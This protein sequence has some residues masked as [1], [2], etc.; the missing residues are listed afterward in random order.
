MSNQTILHYQITE[1]IYV[2]ARALL[3]KAI[4]THNGNTVT[5][6]TTNSDFPSAAEKERLTREYELAKNLKHPNIAEV[7]NIMPFKNTFVLEKQFVEG[8]TVR[9]YF[10]KHQPKLL[11]TVEIAIQIVE[12]LSY[13]HGRHIINKDINGNNII[14]NPNTQK[15]SLIDFGISTELSREIAEAKS[16]EQLEGTL[17]YIAPEQTG[18]VNKALDHRCD[19][20]SVGVLLYKIFT[21]RLPFIY[22]DANELVYA[23]IAQTPEPPHFIK[24]TIP[25]VVSEIILK[26]MRK[27]A[28]ER[29]QS[30]SGLLQD[31]KLCRRILKET[32]LL[33]TFPIGRFDVS[34]KFIVS[35]KLYGREAERAL[36]FEKF[37]SVL[38]EQK[39][40]ITLVTG[41]SGVGKSM[42]INEIQKSLVSARGF[43]AVGKFEQLQQNIPYSAFKRAFGELIDYVSTGAANSIAIWRERILEAVAGNGQILIE[44]IPEIESI[45]GQQEPL[46]QLPALEA[47]NRM[48]FTL[49]R[50]IRLF[51]T[52]EHP[53]CVFIDD[54][55]WADMA[56]I[57]FLKN[58]LSSA[59]DKFLYFIG[60]YRDNEVDA[61]HPIMALFSSIKEEGTELSY[62][63]VKNL[64]QE[65]VANLVADTLNSDKTDSLQELAKIVYQKTSGNAFFVNRLL[66]ALNQDKLISFDNDKEKWQWD[67]ESVRQKRFTD[68]VVA[69][70]S[71]K[72][73]DL[74]DTCTYLLSVAAVLGNEFD[75]AFLAS[76]VKKTL[77]EVIKLLRPAL[78]EQLL[79]KRAEHYAFQHDRIQEAAY[80]LTSEED[81]QKLHYDLAILSHQDLVESGQDT[82]LFEVVNHY[83]NAIP[84][85]KSE[86]EQ[87]SLL[88]LNTQAAQKAYAANAFSSA[89]G[90]LAHGKKIFR[91]AYWQTNYDL[92]Y[93]FYELW[94]EVE[95]QCQRFEVSEELALEATDKA[96]TA[97]DKANILNML[98][99]HQMLRNEPKSLDTGR[100]ALALLGV[101]VPDDAN[102]PQAVGESIGALMGTIAGRRPAEFLD[103][104]TCA[105]RNDIVTLRVLTNLAPAAFVLGN[106]LYWTFVIVNAARLSIE[107][108]NIAESATAY[109]SLGI[110]YG[111]AFS[112]YQTGYELGVL[113]LQLTEKY[114]NQRIRTT[115]LFVM[116]N[117]LH[118]W[119]RP[120]S[121]GSAIMAEAVDTGMLS[122]ELLFASYAASSGCLSH[123]YAASTLNETQAA[124]KRYLE[125]CKKANNFYSIYMAT[126][127]SYLPASLT[128]PLMRDTP[129]T[130]EQMSMNQLEENFAKVNPL[131]AFAFYQSVAHSELYLGNYE[132]ALQEYI[133]GEPA[134]PAVVGNVNQIDFFSYIPIISQA[135]L[136]LS[137]NEAICQEAR[138]C[139][140]AYLPK[141]EMLDGLY[142]VN[143]SHKVALVRAM[144]AAAEGD[145]NT[146][147]DCFDTAI[148]MARDNGFLADYALAY[149]LAAVYYAQQKRKKIHEIYLSEAY[150]IYQQWGATEK[151]ARLDNQYAAVL[152]K[153]STSGSSTTSTRA[154]TTTASTTS[155]RDTISS[156][157]DLSSV[158]KAYTVLSSE[159]VLDK[160][161]DKLLSIVNENAGAQRGVLLLKKNSIFYVASDKGQK[162]AS[163]SLKN[164]ELPE[165]LTQHL[166]PSEVINYSINT[167]R[168]LVLN[169]IQQ[170]SRFANNPYVKAKNSRSILCMPLVYQHELIGIIFLENSLSAG[171]F[172][173][174]RQNILNVL[175]SQITVSVM[176]ALLYE[177]LEEKVRERTTQL[178]AAY[179]I[180]QRKNEDITSSINYA[181]RIQAA[182]LPQKEEMDQYINSFVFYR[183]RDIVSGD[184]YWFAQKN[185]YS[186]LIAADCTGHGIPGALMSMVG[187]EILNSIINERSIYSPDDILAQLHIGIAKGLKQQ[188]TGSRDG[189]DLCVIK[190][191]KATETVE[192]AGAMNPI[193]YTQNGELIEIKADKMPIGGQGVYSDRTFTK[194]SFNYKSGEMI[195]L[196][197]D[198]F[199][200]QFGGESNRKYLVKRFREFLKSIHTYS[201]M[202]QEL[203]LEKEHLAWRGSESQVDDILVIG[204]RL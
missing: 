196:S 130:S 3:S 161:C 69:F 56:S 126:I 12:A 125:V 77:D 151:L 188:E 119:V 83:N 186:I 178:S 123:Y 11:E 101:I 49:D 65:D 26:L 174:K 160:L 90:F 28:D 187:N 71:D 190:I 13:I 127:C 7:Y 132:L 55:Q 75:P 9:E 46:E 148:D 146:A 79:L 61:S 202:E 110:I 73:R 17:D 134:L 168:V 67:I 51:A 194:Y 172:T 170:D 176:N 103:L 175:S 204:V 99:T 102:L 150:R 149:E 50:F 6:K 153:K 24:P 88:Q 63:E 41:A 144:R 147:I 8:I 53:L 33:H 116:G 70:I 42:L 164:L 182:I 106:Q 189:M 93:K 38:S 197:T 140:E 158:L 18:R 32:G 105:E 115:S 2:S 82:L 133:K 27:D 16:A 199:Q 118:S 203:M 74:P 58:M 111:A 145:N 1:N 180:I 30:A 143:H 185:G 81:R 40:K 171:V 156:T 52:A 25:E 60:A 155:S 76:F 72:L 10:N 181:R 89:S 19:L 23:H 87:L 114:K 167:K 47:Q 109:N 78:N 177:N 20:Y 44:F 91:D 15:I 92:A 200:D 108:G 162:D 86:S 184:F 112:D 193:Y 124:Q 34:S 57:Q 141:L 84:L 94:V 139:L 163:S 154:S 29:Y 113:S 159:V 195:Y 31:L 122:G 201:L 136:W 121:E 138:R 131:W 48:Q 66:T 59:N 35:Q 183:P 129:F 36:L 22:D 62:I 198:G 37:E 169:D 39:A 128:R 165:I 120:S 98:V 191:V 14:I 135:V 96:N 107:R 192:Y 21:G 97:A 43:Y 68:N 104:P 64:S 95:Y 54:L 166:L 80:A 100:E 157:I 45:I 137:Q 179:E 5:I 4:N 85:V 142:S 117:F 173:E 152:S